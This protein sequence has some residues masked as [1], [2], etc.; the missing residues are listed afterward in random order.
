MELALKLI[1]SNH[2]LNS[3]ILMGTYLIEIQGIPITKDRF[4]SNIGKNSANLVVF[5]GQNF[6]KFRT[7]NFA[8]LILQAQ[9][10]LSRNS[11]KF[12]NTSHDQNSLW[13]HEFSEL[14]IHKTY[15]LDSRLTHHAGSW[16]FHK[17][18]FWDVWV[19]T[20]FLQMTSSCPSDGKWKKVVS[21]ANEMNASSSCTRAK[22][23]VVHAGPQR[24]RDHYRVISLNKW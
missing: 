23:R 9:I 10:S 15:F 21:A 20:E 8:K 16:Q 19:L 17:V 12:C 1:L 6:A 2:H 22:W 14:T 4:A 5:G 18:P 3:S 11:R 13:F 7:P 24:L